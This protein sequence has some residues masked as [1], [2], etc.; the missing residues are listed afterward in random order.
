M[1][2]KPKQ[3]NPPKRKIWLAVGAFVIIGGVVVAA[4]V[5]L[6]S[7]NEAETDQA[8]SL[9][10]LQVDA[11]NPQKI[12]EAFREYIKRD[13]L[14]DEQRRQAFRKMRETRRE[15]MKAFVDDFYAAAEEDKNSIL[16]DHIAE[17]QRRMADR[18][19][20]RDEGNRPTAEEREAMRNLF[21]SRSQA[22]RKSDSES[23]NADEMARNMAYRTALRGRMSE[24]GISMPRGRGGP[25]RGGGGG[26][27]GGGGGGRGGP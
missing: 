8:F 21:Q 12:R 15:G 24:R 7:G 25:G 11:D 3:K 13:D 20:R 27:R 19:R 18:E 14:T 4:M 2:N 23:R 6:P 9:E 5:V 1:D 17:I 22:E 26:M 16:D 10:Q